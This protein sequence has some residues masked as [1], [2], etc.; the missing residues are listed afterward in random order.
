MGRLCGQRFQGRQD[1]YLSYQ[2]RRASPLPVKG[3]TG[4]PKHD[5]T[6]WVQGT[7]LLVLP[8]KCQMVGSSFTIYSRLSYNSQESEN[9][10]SV[11]TIPNVSFSNYF[12][13]SNETY[14]VISKE[15]ADT[16]N[17]LRYVTSRFQDLKAASIK[18]NT[19]DDMMKQYEP[20]NFVPEPRHYISATILLILVILACYFRIDKICVRKKNMKVLPITFK[21]NR[22]TKEDELTVDELEDIPLEDRIK[23]SRRKLEESK[24]YI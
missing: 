2:R 22:K 14:D 10:S 23:M 16:N 19:L 1:G 21:R 17:H 20:N 9:I 24:S 11:I 3:Q 7:G 8:T 13:F 5:G 6:E 15:L 18:L 4:H 12:N